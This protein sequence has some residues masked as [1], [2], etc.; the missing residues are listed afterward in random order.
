MT[1]NTDVGFRLPLIRSQEFLLGFYLIGVYLA[2]EISFLTG[3]DNANTILFALIGL[4]IIIRAITRWKDLATNVDC[5]YPIILSTLLVWLTIMQLDYSRVAFIHVVMY[6]MLPFLIYINDFDALK[7]LRSILLLSILLIP[8]AI[9]LA[10]LY[11]EKW[12]MP[13]SYALTT[14]VVASIVLIRYYAKNLRQTDMILIFVSVVFAVIM[15][16]Y[17]KRGPILVIAVCVLMVFL[18]PPSRTIELSGK[19]IAALAITALV[20]FFVI[21]NLESIFLRLIGIFNSVGI[22]AGAISRTLDLVGTR[23]GIDAGRGELLPVSIN[24]FLEHPFLGN[25]LGSFYYVNAGGHVMTYP[26]NFVLQ[27]LDDGGAVLALLVLTP[28]LRLFPK[29]L[30]SD[31]LDY[32]VMYI[33]L[34]VLAVPHFLVSSEIF[35]Q[36]ELWCLVAYSHYY[37]SQALSH[38]ES[39]SHTSPNRRPYAS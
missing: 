35:H 27:L 18:K 20:G 34:F 25:G 11:D 21:T 17:G 3:F 36:P 22:E 16:M 13:L 4:A 5:I 26:H 7:L 23:Y 24:L 19:Q 33:F 14:P 31:H 8:S 9:C 2:N 12:R 30:V 37:N 29:M 1:D 39:A 10:N 15:L 32:Y 28:I 38:R 6:A